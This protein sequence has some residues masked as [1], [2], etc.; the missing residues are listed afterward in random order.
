MQ[1]S[2]TKGE[3]SGGKTNPASNT[4]LWGRQLAEQSRWDI[5]GGPLRRAQSARWLWLSPQTLPAALAHANQLLRE[6][7]LGG[8][9]AG[10]AGQALL[11]LIPLELQAVLHHS[12]E[13]KPRGRNCRSVCAAGGLL[14]VFALEEPWCLL[15]C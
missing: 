4:S 9:G 12:P 11:G 7:A 1:E 14:T 8:A 3:N 2:P 6:F 13:V 5:S 10:E 15:C